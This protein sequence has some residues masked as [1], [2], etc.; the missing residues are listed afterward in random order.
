MQIKSRFVTSRIAIVLIG[1]YAVTSVYAVS[2]DPQEADD[3]DL[4]E[5]G[6]A[7]DA[8]GDSSAEAWEKTK[9]ASSDVWQATKETSAQSWEATKEFSNDAWEATREFSVDAWDSTTK[10]LHGTD[11][12]ATGETDTDEPAPA[13]KDDAAGDSL[14]L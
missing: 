6:S 11:E 1:L 2:V 9:A 7:W 14:S 3:Q 5:N 13:D 8:A 10:W 4:E 12:D